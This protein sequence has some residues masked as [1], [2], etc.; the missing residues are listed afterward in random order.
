MTAVQKAHCMK[1][2]ILSGLI[3]VLGAL[4]GCG[5]EEA[6]VAADQKLANACIAGVDQDMGT[7]RIEYI[8][9]TDFYDVPKER[10]LRRVMVTALIKIGT[11]RTEKAF[12]CVFQEKFSARKKHHEA[13]IISYEKKQFGFNLREDNRF[14]AEQM[15]IAHSIL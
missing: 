4:S 2:L 15:A 12:E 8:L 11:L 1:I 3:A 6:R 7:E 13:I 5:N 14:N 9:R 10:S